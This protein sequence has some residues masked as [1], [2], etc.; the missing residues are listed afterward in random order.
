MV[1]VESLLHLGRFNTKRIHSF[2]LSQQRQQWQQY[3]LTV[4]DNMYGRFTLKICNKE[5][6]KS[7]NTPG[8]K[9]VSAET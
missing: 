1:W 6:R 3:S 7:M 5:K 8:M 4:H 2:A 9:V